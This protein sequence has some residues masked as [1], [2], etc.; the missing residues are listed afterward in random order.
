M[1]GVITIPTDVV[2]LAIIH[3]ITDRITIVRITIA[4]IIIDLIG[5]IVIIIGTKSNFYLCAKNAMY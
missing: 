1:D 5:T 4:H 2:G 3:T